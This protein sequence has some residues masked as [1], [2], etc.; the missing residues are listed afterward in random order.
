MQKA[1]PVFSNCAADLGI[2]DGVS[3]VWR[4]ASRHALRSKQAVEDCALVVISKHRRARPAEQVP[5]DLEHVVLRAG[6]LR[7]RGMLLLQDG[8]AD[9]G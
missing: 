9:M 3:G 1:L 8:H 5:R 2:Q 7:L 4:V 6:L